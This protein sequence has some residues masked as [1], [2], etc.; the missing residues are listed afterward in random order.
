M[1]SFKAFITTTFDAKANTLKPKLSAAA[2]LL[3]GKSIEYGKVVGALDRPVLEKLFPMTPEAHDANELLSGQYKRF[4]IDTT[5]LLDRWELLGLE[6]TD[7]PEWLKGFAEVRD[8][9]ASQIAT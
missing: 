5:L 4:N 6:E 7:M 8:L 2:K 1:D 9:I 3:K